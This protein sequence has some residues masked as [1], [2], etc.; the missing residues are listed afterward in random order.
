MIGSFVKKFFSKLYSVSCKNSDENQ[1]TYTI[2]GIKIKT[3]NTRE[4]VTRKDKELFLEYVLNHQLDRSS[5]VEENQKPYNFEA[6]DVN[7]ISFYLPQFHAIPE[8]DKWFMKG[9]TEWYNVAKATPQFLGHYQPH[10]P[11]DMGFYSLDTTDTIKR[12]IELAKKN[13]INGFCFYYYWFNGQKLLE[14][15]IENFLKDKNL[16]INFC[17]FWDSSNWTNTWN[18]GDDNEIMYAQKIDNDTAKR[19]MDD[20]LKY[21]KDDRYIKIDNKPVFV[22]S[23]PKNFKKEEFD[24][25]AAKIR[26]IAKNE[27]FEDLYLMSLRGNMNEDEIK[28]WGFDAM[29]EFFPLGIEDLIPIKKEKFINPKFTGRRYDMEKFIKEKKYLYNNGIKVFKNCFPMWDN[30]ARKCYKKAQIYP[31]SPKMY[32]TWLKDIIKWTK[33]NHG[34]NEQYVFI[35]AWNEWAE[36]AHLEPDQKYGYAFLNATKEAMT[37]SK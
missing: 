34:K 28:A 1:K 23:T 36:G 2:L 8:N 6:N 15:P 10:L 29:L 4:K 21:A 16:D 18:G 32:K 35:N 14:K 31:S 20:F 25:F 7:L 33:E 19:F 9:F 37:E 26:Q 17:L 13:G 5:F 24:K 27:G 22:V 12:Q 30:T 11:I 3:R